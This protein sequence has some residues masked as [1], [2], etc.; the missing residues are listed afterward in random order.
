MCSE[1]ACSMYATNFYLCLYAQSAGWSHRRLGQKRQESEEGTRAPVCCNWKVHFRCR[2]TAVIHL[3]PCAATTCAWRCFA[4]DY[5]SSWD[6]VSSST[7]EHVVMCLTM[8]LTESVI[9]VTHTL[10]RHLL[11]WIV[12]QI[13][14]SLPPPLF[15]SLHLTPSLSPSPPSPPLPFPFPAPLPSPLPHTHLPPS[16]SVMAT[17]GPKLFIQSFIFLNRSTDF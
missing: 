15:P 7:L 8:P 5:D 12:A 11:H 9:D 16:A 17:F 10:S 14:P 2:T 3:H 1:R 6:R 4:Q 13:P